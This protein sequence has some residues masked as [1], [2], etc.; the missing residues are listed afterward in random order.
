MNEKV[1]SLHLLEDVLG[2]VAVFIVSIVMIFTEANILDPIL[3]ALITLYILRGVLKNLKETALI[4]LQATPQ[5]LD[6]SKVNQ[7]I[8]KQSNICGIHDTHIWSLDGEKNILSSHIVINKNSSKEDIKE[9]K[10]T[11]K[12]KLNDIGISHATLEIEFVDEE[13]NENFK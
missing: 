6:T 3:S 8:K 9:V 5:N 11:L 13:C 7:E 1:I 4:F 2:W 12:D 10:H